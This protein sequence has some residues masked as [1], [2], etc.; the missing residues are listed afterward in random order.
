[1][2][3]TRRRTCADRGCPGKVDEDGFC[4]K[5][6]YPCDGKAGPPEPVTVPGMRIPTSPRVNPWDEPV[7][8]PP[9]SGQDP[10]V[11]P[12]DDFA[13]PETRRYCP[14]CHR[15]V[16][17][18]AGFCSSCGTRYSLTPPL[19]KGEVLAGHEI[20]R[21]LGHG[22][23]GWV[24]L[25]ADLD[26]DRKLRVLKGQRNPRDRNAREAFELERRALVDLDHPGI[27]AITRV[28]PPQ[29]PDGVFYLAMEYVRGRT[30]ED[31]RL[32]AGSAGQPVAA[33]AAQVLSWGEQILEAL[34]YL[35][36][37][38]WLYCDLKPDNVMLTGTR[39]KIIDFGAVRRIDDR[40]STPWGTRGFEAPEVQERGPAG[41]SVRSDLY[42]VGRTLG[43]LTLATRTTEFL[44]RFPPGTDPRSIVTRDTLDPFIRLL[45]RATATDPADRFGTAE[46]MREQLAGVR[47]Q[48]LAVHEGTPQPGRSVLFSPVSREFAQHL[49]VGEVDPLDAVRALPVPLV[50]AD[51]PAVSFLASLGSLDPA[52]QLAAL[53]GPPVDSPA[54]AYHRIRA[55]L[56]AGRPGEAREAAGALPDRPGDWSG[57]WHRGLVALAGADHAAARQWFDRVYGWLP[58]EIAAR[59]GNAVASELARDWPA[60]AG[61]YRGVWRTDHSAVAAGFGLA[62][63]LLAVK[64]RSAAAEVLLAVPAGAAAAVTA[65][66]GAIDLLIEPADAARFADVLRAAAIVEELNVPG[67]Q[68]LRLRIRVLRAALNCTD[69]PDRHPGGL[70]GEPVDENGLRWAL[71]RQLRRLAEQT[72][73]SVLRCALVDLSYTFRPATWW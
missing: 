59:L 62:R 16:Q 34:G 54:V 38:G 8:I 55:L 26:T 2:T 43:A 1:M 50:A 51:D 10:L 12:T 15:R 49:D 6:G 5:W 36:Q 27:V 4:L 20:I 39:I 21:A 64:D 42:T 13:V 30:L 17:R 61:D 58:G 32:T 63:A 57:W 65:R 69:R 31:A 71:Y 56:A 41:P 11:L 3:T 24:F 70:F 14:A 66:T 45:A 29:V 18:V 33:V 19:R 48:L 7:E 68:G 37:S 73:D 72:R 23:V 47:R 25:A 28:V 46:Q 35:H 52:Q 40:T 44:R 53:E 9:T 67:S 60:A 22:G